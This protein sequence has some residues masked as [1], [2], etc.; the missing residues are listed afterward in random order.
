M[1]IWDA[2]PDNAFTK[3]IDSVCKYVLHHWN[4]VGVMNFTMIFLAI[5]SKEKVEDEMTVSIRQRALVYLAYFLFLVHI[6]MCLP[7]GSAVR[8]V[9]VAV[10]D[11]IMQD[12]G[13]MCL[14]YA[15]LYKIM[16]LINQWSVGDEE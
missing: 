15:A 7:D 4:F 3:G 16:F 12:F 14:C 11:F 9:A 2:V 8:S 1:C 10:R 13:I 6:L 5:F